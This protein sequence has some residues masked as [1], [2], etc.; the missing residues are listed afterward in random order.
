MTKYDIKYYIK[1]SR[2]LKQDHFYNFVSGIYDLFG[3][4]A[5]YGI[6]GFIGLLGSKT[7]CKERHYFESDYDVVA[8]EIVNNENRSIQIRSIYKNEKSQYEGINLLNAGEDELDEIINSRSEEEPMI[9]NVIDKTETSKYENTLPIHRKIYEIVNMEMYEL[10]LDAKKL[11]PKAELVGI[12]TGCLV[13]NKIKKDIALNEEIG[14]VK[15]RVPESN[16]YTLTKPI[17]RTGTYDLEYTQ[18]N[19][20]KENNINNAFQDGL[21]IYGMSGTSKTTKLL[22]LKNELHPDEHITICPTHKA[23]NLVDGYTIHRI[24]GINPFDFSY[25]Y[26]RAQD[27]KNAGIKYASIYEASMVSERIWCI[28]CHLKKEFNF[29]FIGLGDFKQ[30]KP[31]NEEHIDFQNSWLVKHLFDNN[32]CEITKVHR[33]GENKLLQDAY[34]CAYGKSIAFK[35]YGNKECDSSLGWTNACVDTLNSKYNEK[36]VKSYDN[37]KEVKGHCNTKYILHKN[38]QLMAYT[39]SLNKKVYNSEKFYSCWFC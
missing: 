34:D 29:V 35:R 22:Q 11:N 3:C 1:P 19:N 32:N 33:F 17:A 5:K 18:W 25:E 24:F 20:I 26:T 36:Y 38:L 30:L 27:L 23:C 4:D 16:Q 15:K 14:G 7:I 37:V 13:F 2:I 9:Y 39:S 12:K 31:V 21:L 6:N 8:N 10:Y 28:L